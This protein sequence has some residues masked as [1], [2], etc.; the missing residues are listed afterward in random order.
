MQLL[1]TVS[2]RKL[3]LQAPIIDIMIM[4]ILEDAGKDRTVYF[5]TTVNPQSRVNLDSY[6][7]NQ[8]MVHE[9]SHEKLNLSPD[10]PV[11]LDKNKLE[12]NL[13]NIYRFTNLNNDNIYYNSDLQRILQNY[14][15]LFLYLAEEY[16]A[17]KSYD[18]MKSI[19]LY[20]EEVMPENII[21]IYNPNLK[22]Y[23][24]EFFYDAT[25]TKNI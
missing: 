18:K 6:L 14:R 13:F 10:Y 23:S 12:E 1:C 22:L 8:G 11:F 15:M 9:V 20:M 4:K 19:L 3:L 21:K 24:S 16:R 2:I 17:T 7:I 5:A 25:R